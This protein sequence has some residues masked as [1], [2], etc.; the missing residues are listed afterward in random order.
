MPNYKVFT[1]RTTFDKWRHITTLFAG[2]EVAASNNMRRRFHI[3]TPLKFEMCGVANN[4]KRQ[5][6]YD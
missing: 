4:K 1:R 5:V 2:D 6:Y 3:I